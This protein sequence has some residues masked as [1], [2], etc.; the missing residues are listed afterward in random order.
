MHSEA[1]PLVALLAHPDDEF[2]VFPH[3]ECA[4][5]GGRAVHVAWLTDGGWGGQ[6]IERRRNESVGVLARLGVNRGQLYFMGEE[7]GVAD[8]SL[9]LRIGEVAPRVIERLGP[10]AAQADLLI[11][12]WEG[13]HHDHDAVTA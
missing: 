7:L 12:A 1:P 9:H 11:P 10:L 5:R 6:S 4:A 13:G 2:G 3:L 8:G